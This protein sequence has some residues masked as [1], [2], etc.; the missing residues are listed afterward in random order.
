MIRVVM[1]GRL[2]NNLFQYATGRVLAEKHAVPLVLDGAWFNAEG[3][4]QVR[5]IRRLPIAASVQRRFSLASRVLRKFSGKHPWEYAG[6]PVYKESTD[7]QR[8][9]P[10]VLSLPAECVLMGYFQSPLFFQNI[11]N[12]LRRELET[13]DLP[14]P[15]SVCAVA[16]RMRSVPSVA[17]HVRRTDYLT[18]PIFQVCDEAYYRAAMGRLR[19]RFSGLR[20]FLFSDDPDWCRAHFQAGDEEI[21]AIA[22]AEQD[23]LIDLHLMKQ[24]S[25]H[26]IANSSY[27]WWAAWLGKKAGQSVLCPPRWY[28]GEIVAP[29]KE[30]L[31]EGWEL[32]IA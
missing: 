10:E 15:G 30:K 25:H 19:A 28:A 6:L 9:R 22:G 14:W 23:P 29:I 1:L 18:K 32:V 26:V 24:A 13:D 2:G 20:F 17:V 8:F 27:S 31:A 5:C 12:T 11:E 4:N 16:D 3:W 7:D 21:V